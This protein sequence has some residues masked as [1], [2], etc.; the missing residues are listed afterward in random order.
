MLNTS[1]K[2][3]WGLTVTEGNACGLPVVA[4]DTPGLRDSVVPGA[5]VLVPFGRIDLLAREVAAVLKNEAR[6]KEMSA[7][8]VKAAKPFDW[9]NAAAE[10]EAVLLRAAAGRR[11]LGGK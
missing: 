2:E 1:V 8:A 9:N 5:G 6:R 7:A 3:G 11:G 10:T 4:Y